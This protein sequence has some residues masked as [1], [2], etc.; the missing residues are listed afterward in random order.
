LDAL[1]FLAAI[2]AVGVVIVGVI[3]QNGREIKRGLSIANAA[4]SALLRNP[5]GR[6]GQ[7]TK[8]L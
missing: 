6:K 5:P 7:P 1:L 8:P 3:I 2:F 4:P